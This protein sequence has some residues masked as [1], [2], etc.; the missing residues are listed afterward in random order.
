MEHTK[1]SAN[2][3]PVQEIPVTEIDEAVK[4]NNVEAEVETA[5]PEDKESKDESSSEEEEKEDEASKAMWGKIEVVLK[6]NYL[7][8]FQ[9]LACKKFIKDKVGNPKD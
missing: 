2:E 7:T 9:M 6:E 4:A 1:K 5:K 8:A 3:D